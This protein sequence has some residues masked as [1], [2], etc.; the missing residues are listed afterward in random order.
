MKT[1]TR[2]FLATIICIYV[3]CNVTI[4]A[5]NTANTFS[6]C[7]NDSKNI[8]GYVQL[9][10]DKI[11]DTWFAVSPVVIDGWGKT[12]DMGQRF[13]GL[14][15][16]SYLKPSPGSIIKSSIVPS[17][18]YGLIWSTDKNSLPKND[19]Q[20]F[21]NY[22]LPN[23]PPNNC[24]LIVN[25]N[26]EPYGLQFIAGDG[27]GGTQKL[28]SNTTYYFVFAELVLSEFYDDPDCSFEV[29][30]TVP[31][32]D[33][34]G[35]FITYTASENKKQN[36][37]KFSAN[38]SSGNSENTELEYYYIS[39]AAIGP[40]GNVTTK[41]NIYT[42]SA[43]DAISATSSYACQGNMPVIGGL[44]NS[45]G[46]TYQWSYS[47]SS[48]TGQTIQ[49][50]NGASYTPPES[51]FTNISNT[52][53]T[54]LVFSR[55]VFQNGV[56]LGYDVV[57]ITYFPAGSSGK[58]VPL[59]YTANG[60]NISIQPTQIKGSPQVTWQTS[61]SLNGNYANTTNGVSG[62]A[63]TVASS[64]QNYYRAII[65]YGDCTSS[66]SEVIC[67]S[68]A[69]AINGVT[70]GN[71]TWMTKDLRVGQFNDGT[72]INQVNA[73][74][75]YKDPENTKI[76]SYFINTCNKTDTSYL[77]NSYVVVSDKNVCP[78]GWHVATTSDFSA[79]TSSNYSTVFTA[80]PVTGYIN[81]AS[82][83]SEGGGKDCGGNG[84]GFWWDFSL[85]NRYTSGGNFT[86]SLQPNQL[87][88]PA[89]F[90]IRCVK[91]P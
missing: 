64:D 69:N 77:Y 45:G 34:Q 46:H 56:Q 90:A 42:T 38:Y 19:M 78:V 57:P 17:T 81:N 87:G 86:A 16:K 73:I 37:F 28:N 30:K 82:V 7:Y 74:E 20:L 21:S 3:N 24:K 25:G 79:I 14:Y 41:S 85:Y 31:N 10:N 62:S 13:D 22:L 29:Q 11:S 91:N 72:L 84:N 67:P 48:G 9:T 83:L 36:V 61:T 23:P 88:K 6:L 33:A 53:P 44:G 8:L 5:Q 68:Q 12:V 55:G 4:R 58:I 51:L 75:K 71:Q 63:L 47:L 66:L 59:K 70:V 1:T 18:I 76:P 50:A 43:D 39:E 60:T 54:T 26:W 65:S 27:S 52:L 49:G 2:F 40:I 32:E 35:E 89:G 80:K 15:K